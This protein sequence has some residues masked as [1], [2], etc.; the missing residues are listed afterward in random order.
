MVLGSWPSLSPAFWPAR[1]RPLQG[2][3]ER[4]HGA[5]ASLAENVAFV[6]LGLTIGLHTLPDSGALAI[7]LVLAVLLTVIVRP[8]L[9]GLLLVPV[10]LAWGSGCSCCGPGSRVR[11]QSCWAASCSP[12]RSQC[13]SAVWRHRG[14]GGLLGHRAGRPGAHRGGRPARGADAHRGAR[15]VKFGVRVRQEPRGLRRHVVAPGSPPTGPRSRAGYRR[16]R[17][18]QLPGPRRP[19][20]P[21]RCATRLPVGDELLALTD[22]ARDPDLT[23]I[24]P[25]AGHRPTPTPHQP[26]AVA[27]VPRVLVVP[28]RR[29]HLK[30][31]LPRGH[32]AGRA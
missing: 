24:S 9:V 13:D 20:R 30:Q 28:Q 1:P 6:V 2:K 25:Q 23:P 21:G 5:L 14:R 31:H 18:D 29:L 12:P 3:I 4:L 19:P 10:R 15:T 32:H 7:G 11:C 8:V 16:G 22:P 27:A 26:D 17:V